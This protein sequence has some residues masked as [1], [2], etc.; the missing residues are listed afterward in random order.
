M[1]HEVDAENEMSRCMAERCYR[2]SGP[3]ITPDAFHAYTPLV[4]FDFT[5][6]ELENY[7]LSYVKLHATLYLVV[8][9]IRR[10]EA[11]YKAIQMEN[12]NSTIVNTHIFLVLFYLYLY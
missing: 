11:I 9:T 1:H 12:K 3:H 2:M 10:H 8:N 5:I 6:D 4:L 7:K